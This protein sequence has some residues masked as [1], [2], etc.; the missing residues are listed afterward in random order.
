MAEHIVEWKTYL[1]VWIALMCLMALTAGCLLS[2]SA[3]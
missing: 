2:T 3:I 1:K